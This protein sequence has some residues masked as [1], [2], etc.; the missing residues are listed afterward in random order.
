MI[1]LR[2]YSIY[3]RCASGFG[4]KVFDLISAIYLKNK[5][6]VTT[7][8]AVE[9]SIYDKPSDPFFGNVF[10]T[11]YTK[12]NYI[13]MNKY[14]QLHQRLPIVDIW[15]NSL[16]DLPQTIK[17]NVHFRGLYRFAYL[18]YSS[19]SDEDKKIFTINP[20]L[21][22]T[23]FQ[24][25][26]QDTK[27]ACVHIRY[28]DKLC[29]ALEEFQYTKYTTFMMPI[30]TPQY[31]IDQINE[32]LTKPD[33]DH[34]LILTDSVDLVKIYIGPIFSNNPKIVLLDSHCLD[35]FYLMTKAQYIVLSHSTFSFS[36]AYIDS[37]ATCY[38]LKKYITNKKDYLFQDD[39][40]SPLWIILDNKEYV[41][42]F[43]QTLLK[44]IVT[45]Y[46]QCYKY[47]ITGPKTRTENS[48]ILIQSRS[49]AASKPK[50]M[51][52][53]K[54]MSK[55]K[56]KSK[57]MS[58]PKS[59]S[60]SK[61]QTQIEIKDWTK[62]KSWTK[63]KSNK[64]IDE[65]QATNNNRIITDETIDHELISP[66][67]FIINN[68]KI[69][70]NVTIYGTLSYNDIVVDNYTDIYGT[71]N[72]S[73]G[74]FKSLNV[75]GQIEITLTKIDTL[76]LNGKIYADM[77]SIEQ[78]SIIGSIYISKCKINKIELISEFIDLIDCE[79]DHLLIHNDDKYVKKINI[80]S[81]KIGQLI[82]HG[83]NCNI[84]KDIITIIDYAKNATFLI[85]KD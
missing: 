82:V 70:G 27:Y 42:N 21:L 34:I 73:N 26:Y 81:S 84:M 45:E 62:S 13:F 8:F 69:S 85:V 71:L 35:S 15:I 48:R 68:S 76:I 63:I 28:G 54:S 29:Y 44:K 77:L 7:Y 51:S 74:V 78:A 18:M 56:S 46:G 58:K 5:Y 50:S 75:S 39:A 79:I 37:S 30:Y 80:K 38:L 23:E 52:K 57:S 65:I 1:S 22:H 60:K 6:K 19:F 20:L 16:E 12:I 31:Y 49:M 36:A 25:K 55:P 3:V 24:Q 33:L 2:Q 53:S 40:I 61:P 41:L 66:G 4:N 10:N 72:G 67:P 59:M 17:S 14:K 9:N 83:D 32:L 64:I 47:I 43:D 11:S